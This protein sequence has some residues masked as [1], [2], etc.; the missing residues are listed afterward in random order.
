ML[1]VPDVDPK[2]IMKTGAGVYINRPIQRIL[3]IFNHFNEFSFLYM[4]VESI[5]LKKQKQK[6]KHKNKK[7]KQKNI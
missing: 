3:M 2:Y 6:K 1:C 4:F 5:L 7:K